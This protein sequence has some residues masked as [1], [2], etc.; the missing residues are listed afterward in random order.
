[1]SGIAGIVNL[2]GGPIDR[3]LLLRMTEA[4]QEILIDGNVVMNR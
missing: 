4:G 3:D 2:D 1:M